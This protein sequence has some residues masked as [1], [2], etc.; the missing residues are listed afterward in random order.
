M[1][2]LKPEYRPTAAYPPPAATSSPPVLEVVTGAAALWFLGKV[3]DAYV[4]RLADK[5]AEST[6]NAAKRIRH[7]SSDGNGEIQIKL[8]GGTTIVELPKGPLT[9]EMKLAFIDLDI[10]DIPH[11]HRCFRWDEESKTWVSTGSGRP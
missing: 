5:L 8:P 4:A 10:A 7:R 11:G 6:I 9:E 3:A 1:F 2:D